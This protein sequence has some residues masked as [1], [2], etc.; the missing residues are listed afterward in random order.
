MPGGASA[1]TT[2]SDCRFLVY[3]NN[4]NMNF[5]NFIQYSFEIRQPLH[6]FSRN[7]ENNF[8]CFECFYGS[9]F[10]FN[11]DFHFQEGQLD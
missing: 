7:P 9:N 2:I 4:Q 6:A 3:F 5:K 10:E 11:Q 8:T 1:I